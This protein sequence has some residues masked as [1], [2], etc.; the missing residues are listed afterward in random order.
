MGEYCNKPWQNWVGGFIVLSIVVL[1]S[2]YGISVMFPSLF[3]S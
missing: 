2:L 3:Q 1:S